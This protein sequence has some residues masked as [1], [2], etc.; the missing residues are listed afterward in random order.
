M[1]KHNKQSQ[2]YD[3]SMYFDAQKTI[4][5]DAQKQN[6]TCKKKFLVAKFYFDEL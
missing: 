1:D 4:F 3:S 2:K 5:K 6:F